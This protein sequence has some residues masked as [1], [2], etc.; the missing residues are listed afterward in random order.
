[1][2]RGAQQ[3]VAQQTRALTVKVPAELFVRDLVEE[4]QPPHDPAFAVTDSTDDGALLDSLPTPDVVFSGSLAKAVDLNKLL[5]DPATD[6]LALF[7]SR[8]DFDEVNIATAIHQL[9]KRKDVRRHD[10]RLRQL[11]ET[12]AARVVDEKPFQARHLAN[13]A[14][15]VTKQGVEAP[16]LLAAI[17]GAAL[18]KI[19]EFKPQE[20]ADTSWAYATAGVP[21]P[22]LFDAIAVAAVH[23]INKFAPQHL[24]NT[25][26]AYATARVTAPALFAAI[27]DAAL[28]KIDAFT[29][30]TLTNTAWAYATADVAAPALFDAIAVARPK[31]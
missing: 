30:P 4:S 9:G 2:R 14:W 7:A 25:A 26:W 15:G 21:A 22:A 31:G 16:A 27:A 24:A 20:L 19:D 23:K 3:R 29:P 6:V 12:A 28:P 10:Q 18:R 5:K 8:D 11:I 1:M 13:M 17:A